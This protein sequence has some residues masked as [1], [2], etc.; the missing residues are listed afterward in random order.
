MD[1]PAYLDRIRYDGPLVPS[2]GTLRLLHRCHMLSVPF[3]N[4]DIGLGREI[5]LDS[6]RFVEKIVDRRRGGF[7]YELNG[8]FA[9]LLAAAGFHVTLLSA[10]VADKDGTARKEFDHLALYAEPGSARPA[11]GCP[12]EAHPGQGWLVDVGFGDSFLEPLRFTP[13]AEQHDPAGEFRLTH[14]GE[15]WRLERRDASGEWRLQYDFSPRPRHLSEFAGMCR[16]HQ[17]SRD[18]HFTRN[19]ICSLA[20]A[21]GRITLSGMRLIVRSNGSKEETTLATEA[22][23]HS[24]LRNYFGI[25]LD[26][27]ST[28]L[29]LRKTATGRAKPAVEPAT[30]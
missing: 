20:T 25:I 22:E 7:C 26:Q 15:R 28:V 2:G 5:V 6:N 4:L 18:S 27:P 21:N 17:T 16:Y 24:A 30:C 1:I 10:R 12:L 8:A 23:W 14:G 3:E 13:H 11:E 9:S 19:R 29:R